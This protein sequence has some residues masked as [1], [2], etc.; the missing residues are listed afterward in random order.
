MERLERQGK[1]KTKGNKHRNRTKNP[2]LANLRVERSDNTIK[3][4][5]SELPYM[6]LS[7]L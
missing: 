4:K 7:K 6:T 1:Q 2:M 3:S 5:T